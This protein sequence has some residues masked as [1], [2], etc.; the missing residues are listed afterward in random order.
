MLIRFGLKNKKR[1]PIIDFLYTTFHF[2]KNRTFLNEKISEGLIC[3]VALHA[4]FNIF[5]EMGVTVFMVPFLFFWL[6]FSRSSF[7]EKENLK[8][9]GYITG[10]YDNVLP[11]KE[12]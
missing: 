2:K 12:S 3:A 6:H 5:L 1:H 4:M 10:E 8:K 11:V 9:Y 7:Q